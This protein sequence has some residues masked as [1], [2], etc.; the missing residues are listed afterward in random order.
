MNLAVI[1]PPNQ[2]APAARAQQEQKPLP[3]ASPTPAAEPYKAYPNQYAEAC[4]QAQDH[5]AADL[6][7]QWRASVAAER[8]AD[9]QVVS[10]YITGGGALLSFISILLV[11]VALRE[12]RRANVIST[13]QT[14]IAGDTAK[15]QLR[16]HIG[17]AETELVTPMEGMGAGEVVFQL[18]NYGGS[19]ALRMEASLA[20]ATLPFKKGELTAPTEWELVGKK[21]AIDVPP[22]GIAFRRMV[23]PNSATDYLTD[24]KDG[25]RSL[26]VSLMVEYL[27]IFG[28]QYSQKTMFGCR[29]PHF[30]QQLLTVWVQEPE[31]IKEQDKDY[32]STPSLWRRWFG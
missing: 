29:G 24:L 11:L 4:Y 22:N 30:R 31:Q 14:K 10:N 8:A 18:K 9:A 13:A 17:V 16:A 7:A 15:Q 25:S 23:L 3:Q 5:N 32:P 2:Q 21:L 12:T 26:W 6:C 20:I 27:D 28:T 19:P 1:Q